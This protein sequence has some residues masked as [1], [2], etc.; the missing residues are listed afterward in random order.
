MKKILVSVDFS[1]NARK[2]IRFAIQFATQT[3]AEVIF[4][5]VANRIVP[6]S[7][8]TWDYT[9]YA[10]FQE[11]Q[12]QQGLNYLVK[13]IKSVYN[14]KLPQGVKYTCVCQSGND[15]A[16][17]I[18]SYAQKHNIDFI[19]AG[20]RGTGVMAKLFGNVATHLITHSPIPVFIIPKNYRIKPLSDLCY[21]S[22]ME[23]P[24]IEIKKVLQLATSMRAKVKVIHFD[25]EIRLKENREKLTAIAQQY[26]NKEVKFL[27]KKLNAVYPLNDHI[28]KIIGLI[29][30]SL[31]VLF[32]K[33][34]R[35]WFDRLLLSSQSAEL[36]FTTKVPLLIFRKTST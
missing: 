30:P 2:A 19:C 31:L 15:I 10:Q 16:E 18:I 27:Y 6:T 29:K 4:Y 35:R 26:E 8:A 32:T 22:D 24:E 17:Q 3:K 1:A 21:A 28:R 5:H 25:Y 11:E 9:Y 36:S 12:E 7:D 13:L 33:Q 14:S 34:N 20:A 23:N